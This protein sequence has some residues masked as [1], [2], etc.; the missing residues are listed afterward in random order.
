MKHIPIKVAQNI[1]K[2]YDFHQVIIIAASAGEFLKE[3]VMGWAE[4][5]EDEIGGR[6]KLARAAA[7]FKAALEDIRKSQHASHCPGH[8]ARRLSFQCVCHVAT[9]RD[10]LRSAGYE[11]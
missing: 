4:A 11:A 1:A 2:E 9:A 5:E 8:G 7:G 6:V 3:K 10:Q